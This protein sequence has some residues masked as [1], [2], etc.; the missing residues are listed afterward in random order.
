MGMSRGHGSAGIRRQFGV[1]AWAW[2]MAMLLTGCGGGGSSTTSPV[3]SPIETAGPGDA[4]H[5]FPMAVGDRW[6][7][8]K[9]NSDG[10][11]ALKADFVA[12]TRTIQGHTAAVSR[13][14]DV[15]SGQIEDGDEYY[16]K[17][18][19]GVYSL[20]PDTSPASLAYGLSR[21]EVLRFPLQPGT[22]HVPV[23][24]ADLDLGVDLDGDGRSER[25]SA[26]VQSTVEATESVT[27]T[28]GTFANAARVVTVLKETVTLSRNSQTLSGTVTFT[29]WYA[30]GVGLVRN[31]QVSVYP[32]ET[33]TDELDLVAYSVGGQQQPANAPTVTSVT[34]TDGAVITSSTWA[35]PIVLTLSGSVLASVPGDAIVVRQADGTL[36]NGL[37]RLVGRDRLEFQAYSALPPGSYSVTLG[38]GVQDVLGRTLKVGLSTSFTVVAPDLMAP[39]IVGFSSTIG[40]TAGMP[41]ATLTLDFS[42]PLAADGVTPAAFALSN[43][44]LRL[45]VRSATLTGPSQVTLQADLDPGQTYSVST[46]AP[47][48]DRAGNVASVTSPTFTTGGGFGSFYPAR[49]YSPSGYPYAAQAGDVDGDRLADLVVAIGPSNADDLTAFALLIYPHQ[50]GGPLET[51]TRVP[52]A[53]AT[54]CQPSQVILADVTADGRT[55][56][57]LGT[58]RCGL[59]IAERSTGGGTWT[60]TTTVAMPTFSHLLV[61][62]VNGDGRPDLVSAAQ[63][64]YALLIA[65]GLAAGGFG[66][67]TRTAL[68][69]PADY[70]STPYFTGLAAGDLDSDGRTDL[71]ALPY[72]TEN[73]QAI[74][75]IRQRGDGT[76][77]SA[78]YLP[79]PALG[80]SASTGGV[81]VGDLDSDGRADLVVSGQYGVAPYVMLFRQEAG[82]TLA[83]PVRLVTGETPI[84][85]ALA[86]M[87]GN[88]R[89]D[90]VVQHL[91]SYARLG[92][93]L[94]SRQ[95]LLRGEQLVESTPHWNTW[96]GAPILGDFNGDGLLD[97]VL[98][99]FGFFRVQYQRP[100]DSPTAVAFNTTVPGARP[101]AAPQASTR[102]GGP[103]ARFGLRLSDV[104]AGSPRSR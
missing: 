38:T 22:R 70:P 91:G 92:L 48:I 88:G 12:E 56:I 52:L 15:A 36:L 66:P 74:M 93:Y 71:V 1:R 19:H 7:Y 95:G 101:T 24:Q 98:V 29:D 47:L 34:P 11:D 104:L 49:N 68:P 64:E 32:N 57:V 23:D 72:T 13:R 75:L 46:S 33:I 81:L 37:T 44:N 65:H 50:T 4:G 102:W 16:V 77:A 3:E 73:A 90:L 67:V 39:T 6:I 85:L 41:D 87:D 2:A 76:L 17:T 78:S 58:V 94:Q 21:V 9:V 100:A 51:Y 86:D 59:L 26:R 20:S 14:Q 31:R 84:G 80:T 69:I 53:L 62:D 54:N 28:A 42:E 103:R 45:P 82:G 18:G 83:S 30:P 35:E 97:F 43:A 99:D 79:L 63:G 60:V 10:T 96:R 25:L 8:R 40:G 27:V 5:H 61:A 55:D 89:P